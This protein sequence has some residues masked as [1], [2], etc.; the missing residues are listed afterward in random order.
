MIDIFNIPFYYIGFTPNIQL[1]KNL[2]KLGFTDVKYFKAI[3]AREMNSQELLK[4]NI[5]STRAYHDL[6]NGR[7]DHIAISS[8]GTVGC[9]LSHRELWYICS[10]KLPYIIIAE[11][12]LSLKKINK[13]DIENIQTSLSQKNGAFISAKINKNSN[14][15]YGAH[16]YF[17]T[18]G[19]A[20]KLFEKSLPV[21]MQTDSYIKHISDIGDIN[22]K[23]YHIS[24]QNSHVSSTADI[25]VK[26]DLPKQLSFY[27]IIV[28]CILFIIISLFIFYKKYK[29]TETKLDRCKSS[30]SYY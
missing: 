24:K 27:I 14:F 7:S 5:I 20:K 22:L 16:L 10:K 12:D 28:F 26:C 19:A 2:K 18:N 23:G 6:K 21:S 9:T 4:K 11:D 8:L 3:D 1:E 15:M 13:T 25:C 17:L 30:C 29:N